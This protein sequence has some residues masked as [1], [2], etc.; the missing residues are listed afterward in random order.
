MPCKVFTSRKGLCAVSVAHTYVDLAPADAGR[1]RID[2][3]CGRI[4]LILG[5]PIV[6]QKLWLIRSRYK[7]IVLTARR[8]QALWRVFG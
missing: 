5:R 7:G 2:F 6:M 3:T 1:H 4:D 8:L